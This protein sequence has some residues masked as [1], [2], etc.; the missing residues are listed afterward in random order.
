MK[1]AI[2]LY[3]GADYEDLVRATGWDGQDWRIDNCKITKGY[4]V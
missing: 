2:L 1:T 3:S 4:K